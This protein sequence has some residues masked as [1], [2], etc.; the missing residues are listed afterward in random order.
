MHYPEH[1]PPAYPPAYPWFSTLLLRLSLTRGKRDT[2]TLS[3]FWRHDDA[4]KLRTC[5][6]RFAVV[7]MD[8]A[9]KLFR[10]TPRWGTQNGVHSGVRRS[11]A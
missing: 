11:S 4:A 10:G 8:H 3:R 5:R 2:R 7:Q 6:Q 1:I 9:A